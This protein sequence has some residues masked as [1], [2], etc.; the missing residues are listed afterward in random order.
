M[1]RNILLPTSSEDEVKGFCHCTVECDH[2][3]RTLD[4]DLAF[5]AK[6]TLYVH[7]EPD[8]VLLYTVEYVA[9]ICG[10]NVASR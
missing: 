7:V 2:H 10:C 9:I 5:K 3:E 1:R 8:S 4:T 6:V